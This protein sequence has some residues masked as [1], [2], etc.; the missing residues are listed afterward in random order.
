MAY[1][2]IDLRPGSGPLYGRLYEALKRAIESGRLAK[3]SR[4]PSIRKLSEDLGL[5]RTTIESAYQQLSVEGYIKSEPQRGYFVIFGS[6]P[7]SP[8]SRGDRRLPP[9]AFLSHIR[10][11]L[12][13]DRIDAS[14]A[15]LKLWKR[16]IREILT[17]QDLLISYGD[18]QGEPALREALSAYA[19][20]LR[21]VAAE[22]ENIVVAAGTQ[23]LLSIVCGLTRRKKV[24][25]E[26]QGFRQAEQVFADCGMEI[27]FLP[28]D[29]AGPSL[30]HLQ[31]SGAKLV[32][33]NPSHTSGTAGAVPMSRRY[34]LLAWAR[35]TGSLII[36][37]D[38][39]GE[40]R[41]NARPI[42]ALQGLG[43][44]QPVVYLGSFSKLLLP[45]VRISY[46]ALPQELASLYRRRASNYNQ[47]ASKTEQL[48]LASYIG[49]GQME[50]HLRRLRKLY[51]EK[52]QSMMRALRAAF[53]HIPFALQETAL[54]CS[55]S[56]P[57]ALAES[58]VH[59][60][61]EGGIRLRY[62]REGGRAAMVIG[63]AGTPLEDI[64]AAVE[65]LKTVWEPFRKELES[66]GGREAR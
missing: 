15:D 32:Y 2:Y 58:L 17:R 20:R 48:A 16:H 35:E 19:Y 4:V 7:L 47:T 62:R 28:S 26:E 3:G 29:G 60:A 25:L 10:F 31:E 11:D 41:Y 8:P 12:G 14:H 64:P 21:G 51:G 33:V 34:E 30:S 22:P 40:L 9:P 38:Y 43:E 1:D 55:F 65:A 6:R 63:F 23:P 5:S 66:L 49:S 57:E 27:C 61:E 39:N 24:A 18:P 50:R 59:S 45:S 37:D 42:P 54:Y 52:S 44:N 13:T 46:M 56:L 36:E 53:P